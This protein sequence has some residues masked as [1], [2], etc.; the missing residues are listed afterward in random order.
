M[1]PPA[2]F[3]LNIKERAPAGL[4]ALRLPSQTSGPLGTDPSRMMGNIAYSSVRKSALH[5]RAPRAC[6]PKTDL[7]RACHHKWNRNNR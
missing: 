5:N 7:A 3:V 2:Y 1:F 6:G 4:Y